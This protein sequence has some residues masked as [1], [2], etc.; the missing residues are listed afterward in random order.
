MESMNKPQPRSDTIA[1]QRIAPTSR[2]S[3]WSEVS[4]DP[5]SGKPQHFV[6][7]IAAGGRGFEVSVGYR[8]CH[9]FDAANKSG[10]DFAA[11][12]YTSQFL[13]G[14][15][16]DGVS[17]SFYGQVAATHVAEFLLKQLWE[18]RKTPPPS[19]DLE[20]S[21]KSLEPLVAE[22]LEN[23]EIPGNLPRVQIESLEKVRLKGTQAVFSCFVFDITAELLTLYSVGDVTAVVHCEGRC[24]RMEGDK[25]GR[26]SSAGKS[27][28]LLRPMVVEKPVGLVLQS[29]G[30]APNWADSLEQIGSPVAFAAMAERGADADDVSF[31]GFRFVESS[32][33]GTRP[34][35]PEPASNSAPQAEETTNFWPELSQ[36]EARPTP[37]PQSQTGQSKRSEAIPV[38][39]SGRRQEPAPRYPRPS[40]SVAYRPEPVRSYP[41]QKPRGDDGPAG[42]HPDYELLI[43]VFL[44][45][46]L[47][48]GVLGFIAGNNFRPPDETLGSLKTH[49][50]PSQ[51]TAN[52]ASKPP[53]TPPERAVTLTVSDRHVD[54]LDRHDYIGLFFHV[55]QDLDVGNILVE[56]DKTVVTFSREEII[57]PDPEA[58]AFVPFPNREKRLRF[59][60][61][62]TH[63]DLVADSKPQI[64]AR[65]H[66]YDVLIKR[67]K[68]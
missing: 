27:D 36:S 13:V 1:V 31:V 18:R 32:R 48:F 51:S 38:S 37:R 58:P 53:D 42:R 8:R 11:V 56:S 43:M 28:L 29:D 54:D 12:R 41:A 64:V 6:E 68:K 21:L 59:R 61:Q 14:V 4:A 15:V 2:S 67:Y 25:K 9:D 26:W 7:T 30:A 24:D 19:A 23:I 5:K 10:Q 45:G 65:G 35:Y 52:R 22:E 39:P 49:S 55:P 46:G 60:V 62:D 16:A 57:H 40:P 33:I 20:T 66:E 44:T 47:V 34:D 63:G 3:D 50:K 17:R